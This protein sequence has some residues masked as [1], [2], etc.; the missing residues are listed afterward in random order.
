MKYVAGMKMENTMTEGDVDKL[1]T[2][3]E[4]YLRD[5]PCLPQSSFDEM[6]ELATKLRSSKI[7]DQCK[8]ART[9]CFETDR[10][11]KSRQQMLRKA[12]TQLHLEH[13]RRYSVMG[14]ECYS[15]GPGGDYSSPTTTNV[16]PPVVLRRRSFAGKPSSP[17]YSPAAGAF[18]EN[19]R[20]VNLS[21]FQERLFQEGLITE[22]MS[23]RI[24]ANLPKSLA[25]TTLRGSRESLKGSRENLQGSTENLTR[26]QKSSSVPKEM[27]GTTPSPGRSDNN[28]YNRI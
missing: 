17:S 22:D 19:V 2:S 11:I 20:D 23:D 27:P 26:D 8:V 24:V 4:S 1:L 10:I 9:R 21:E 13:Q 18:K 6:M 12:R 7:Q 15:P 3:I 25:D 16:L 5:H 14:G 28:K